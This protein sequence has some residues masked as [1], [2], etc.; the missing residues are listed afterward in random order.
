MTT[1]KRFTPQEALLHLQELLPVADIE[2]NE[3]LTVIRYTDGTMHSLEDAPID[4]VER[5]PIVGTYASDY[6]ES[7][8]KTVQAWEVERQDRISL[9]SE[10][11]EFIGV[12]NS[13][14]F[15]EAQSSIPKDVEYSQVEQKTYESALML[16][17]R[18]FDKG[19]T[20]T[21]SHLI[22]SEVDVTTD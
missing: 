7:V 20:K 1:T 11:V 21:E 22:R 15:A 19:S 3:G 17:Q 10:A 16:L 2:L 12:L 6:R 8:T 5:S 4:W 9:V 18:E 13:R 14:Y